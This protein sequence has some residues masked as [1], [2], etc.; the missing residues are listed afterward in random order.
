MADKNEAE[1]LAHGE[2]YDEHELAAHH[3]RQAATLGR[4]RYVLVISVA[5]V[6]A[7]FALIW[8]GAL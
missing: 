8:F 6:A 2:D 4:M 1:S 5:L 7:M 3:A